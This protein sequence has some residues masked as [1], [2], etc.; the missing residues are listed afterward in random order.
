MK[1]KYVSLNQDGFEKSIEVEQDNNSQ[2]NSKK[3]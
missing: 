2:V 3:S 1:T